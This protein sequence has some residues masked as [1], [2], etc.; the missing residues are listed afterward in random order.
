MSNT[1][2]SIANLPDNWN[3]N[4]ALALSEEFV[5]VAKAVYEQL[6]VK[7]EIY[8]TACDCIQFEWHDSDKYLEFEVYMNR[9]N[10]YAIIGLKHIHE[11]IRIDDIDEMNRIIQECFD[12]KDGENE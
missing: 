7:P 1:F 8:P 5:S 12:I 3:G 11:T 4:G 9:V 10:V 6:F 2:E